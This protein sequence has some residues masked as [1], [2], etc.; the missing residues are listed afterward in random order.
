[1]YPVSSA[2]KA[3][4]HAKVQRFRVTGTVG[5]VAFS[6]ENILAGSLS[7][8]NQCSDNDNIGIGQV[9]I[10]ELNCTFMNVP[11]SRYDWYGKEITLY[12]GQ[13]L[14]DGTFE[15]I[16]FGVYT[17]SEAEYT[18][19]GTV[20][21]A[22]DHMAKLDKK[23]SSL[24][25]GTTAY[26]IARKACQSCGVEL[27]TPEGEFKSFA[28][29]TVTLGVYAENDISTYRDVIS[30]LAQ[31]CGCFATASRTGGILFKPY[32][33]APVDTIDPE[34]RFK[35]CSFSDYETRFSGM[36]VVNIESQTTNYYANNPDNALTYN[37]GSNPYLQIS[38]SH[39]LTT[40][41]RNVLN[42]LSVI[43]YVP[44]K[45]TCIGNP[46][47]DL[48]DVLVFSDGLADG[49]RLY[50][51]TKYA[52]THNKGY[53][54]EG[55]G[56]N[57]AL[58]SANSK[59]DKNIAGLI[60]NTVSDD[61]FRYVVLRNGED[62]TVE[63][64]NSQSVMF[65]RY[66]VSK[67]C[68]V[69]FNFEILLSSTPTA[70]RSTMEVKAIYKADGVEITDRYPVETWTA[71]KHI[72]TLQYDLEHDDTV[73]HSFDLWLETD[74]G[75]I[76]IPASD[77]YE[78]ISSTGL[79]ADS[80]WEGTF[81]GEDGNLY[82]VI[83]GQ[84]HKIP[85]RI[86]VGHYPNKTIYQADE[87]LDYTG[88]VIYAVFGNGAKADVTNECTL[89]P[90]SG[91]PYD[92][93]ADYYIEVGYTTNTMSYGTGFNLQYNYITRMDV[94]QLPNKD[95]Y[96]NGETIDYTGLVITA[97]YRDGTSE[98]VTADCDI[99]PVDGTTFIYYDL[100]G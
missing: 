12:F 98:D 3:A 7:V 96:K 85:D 43:R 64:G 72:L 69:R 51:I 2:Y 41:R 100:A 83:G 54:M 34:N 88:L 48:G 26:N 8:S 44:F 55:V 11:L 50:C 32:G 33:T 53:S 25:T 37:L 13:G 57:P 90:A 71:G 79:A 82:I 61:L 16:P 87:P 60:S 89:S 94:V 66:L 95:T 1:M 17:I 93:E 84:A 20:V 59:S 38:V 5:S 42:A 68:H 63:D 24:L 46:A 28:N 62:I 4:M 29:G 70:T 40:M 97:T 81:R 80:N 99:A 78:V 52:W 35:G 92:T 91:T 9:Y 14:G 45:A 23:C 21:K 77:A 73:S 47:Y 27:E 15:D 86:E 74:G 58:A 30:W 65:A 36:S 75:S 10:G 49:D 6:D 18:A 76:T 19:S 31:T 39:S 67:P 22:Y 56:K